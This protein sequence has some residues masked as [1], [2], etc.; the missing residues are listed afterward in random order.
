MLLEVAITF[1]PQENQKPK[2]YYDVRCYKD[3]VISEFN[4]KS[5]N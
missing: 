1:K 5:C 4:L 3:V 2:K